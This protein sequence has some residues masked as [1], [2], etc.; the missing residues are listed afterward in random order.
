V[1]SYANTI[2]NDLVNLINMKQSIVS[3]QQSVDN[4]L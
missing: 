4:A 2:N 1:N 3:A